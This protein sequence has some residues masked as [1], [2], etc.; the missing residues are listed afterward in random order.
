[1]PGAIALV[2]IAAIAVVIDL[3]GLQS[4]TPHVLVGREIATEISQQVQA[5]QGLSTPPQVLCPSREPLRAGLVFECNL[6]RSGRGA[7]RIRVTET[8]K[9]GNFHIQLLG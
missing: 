3:A 1:V 4:H 8:S 6:L 5:I 2:V 7:E 9:A